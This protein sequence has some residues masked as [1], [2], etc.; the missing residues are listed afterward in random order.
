MIYSVAVQFSSTAVSTFPS[1][2][3]S[4]LLEVSV[5][6]YLAHRSEAKASSSGKHWLSST[7]R[8]HVSAGF[9]FNEMSATSVVCN[10]NK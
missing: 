4:N 7:R 8:L 3:L 2:V 9:R 6:P 1:S 10:I 5:S